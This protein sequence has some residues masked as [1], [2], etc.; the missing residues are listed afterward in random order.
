LAP[1]LPATVPVGSGVDL[2]L[3][4]A[5]AELASDTTTTFVIELE[6]LSANLLEAVDIDL[7]L[8][9]ASGTSALVD[10]DVALPVLVGIGDVA[11]SPIFASLG[12][13]GTATASFAITPLASAAAGGTMTY[14]LTGT[15][16]GV[17]EGD[18]FATQLPGLAL[19]VL[20]APRLELE[21]YWP[22]LVHADWS[23]TTG[24]FEVAEPFSIGAVIRN[25]GAAA[26]S[27][28]S[29]VSSGPSFV[30]DL[31]GAP[32]FAGVE[33]LEIDGASAAGGFS[34]PSGVLGDLAP[35]AE[36]RILWTAAANFEASLV[37]FPVSLFVDGVLV[38]AAIVADEPLVHAA[39]TFETTGGPLDDSRVDW[40]VDEP[41]VP[42]PL[43]P[44]TG[45]M[46]TE[47]P[48]VVRASDGS[49]L[50]LV[51][52]TNPAMGPPPSPA[53]LS[54][55]A[56]I[57]AGGPGWHYLRFEDPGG[58]FYDLAGVTRT[59]KALHLGGL[60]VGGPGDVSRVWTTARPTDLT[61]DGLPDIVRRE[62]HLVDFVPVAGTW[63][64]GLAYVESGAS[65]LSANVEVISAAQGGAQSLTL[66]AGPAHAGEIYLVLGSVSGTVP[67]TPVDLALLPLNVDGYFLDLLTNSG[68][69]ALFGTIG[70]LDA[71]GQGSAQ[72][73][74]PAGLGVGAGLAAH[75]A[76][77]TLPLAA[78][79]SF[80]SN[81]VPLF[82]LP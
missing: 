47:F 15:V 50:V 61:G 57:I 13:G 66:D 80:A 26:A 29:L 46:F 7:D 67:G 55:T 37:D 9:D 20:P 78:P 51:P 28:L 19:R 41:S 32:L 45:Q 22:A 18:V 82:V 4:L 27:G 5:D 65:A 42:A 58:S 73:L 38:D 63:E 11:G 59:Q 31:A 68:L 79:V 72:I 17:I 60:D 56:T 39:E 77:I 69:Q 75:H 54:S 23:A 48:S 6:N 53:N 81:A 33:A 16:S 76:F 74:I 70:V 34:L 1:A 43:D 25:T 49:D 36:R 62:V 10:F 3:D 35:G 71:Q 2:H 40:L 24:L 52:E 21:L 12:P 44:V 14:T 30:P 8:V 64:Y